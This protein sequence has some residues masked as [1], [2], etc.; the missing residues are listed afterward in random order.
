[1]NEFLE[2]M[3]SMKQL[4][5]LHAACKDFP[6]FIRD[7][8]SS[9]IKRTNNILDLC[10]Y[11]EKKNAV[12]NRTICITLWF[13]VTDAGVVVGGMRGCACDACCCSEAR[14]FPLTT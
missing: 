14:S 11:H 2:F 7:E 5:R 10:P 1:M 8:M 13:F 4:K 12:F 6:L 9:C 3:L